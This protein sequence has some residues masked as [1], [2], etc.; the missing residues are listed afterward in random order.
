[1]Q[2]WVDQATYHGRSQHVCLTALEAPDRLVPAALAAWCVAHLNGLP[3]TALPSSLQVLGYDIEGAQVIDDDYRPY[4]KEPYW[5]PVMAFEDPG[6][7]LE[8]MW[9]DVVSYDVLLD[10]LAEPA[11]GTAHR[12]SRAEPN[13]GIT[14]P[15]SSALTIGGEVVR[16]SALA[17]A[18]PAYATAAET[19][20]LDVAELPARGA[21]GAPDG[22]GEYRLRLLGA[23]GAVLAE[24]AFT[25]KFDA[26]YPGLDFAS[27]IFN[28]PAPQ[29]L[30][31]VALVRGGVVIATLAASAA[32]PQVTIQAPNGSSHSGDLTVRWTG[33]DADAGATV[34]Y[35]V[36][37]GSEDGVGWRMVS[38]A[39]TGT[40]LTLDTTQHAN[41]AACRL[42]VIA[43]DGFLAG[44][45][46][47]APFSISNPPRATTTWPGDGAAGVP[48]WPAITAS[49]RD[50]MDA[51]SIN[52][53][54]FTLVDA[55]GQAVAGTVSYHDDTSTAVFRPTGLLQRGQQYIA[56][57]TGTIRAAG[58]T[59][60]GS[61][62]FWRFTVR[63]GPETSMYLPLIRR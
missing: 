39:T 41:C 22:T 56:R 20:R 9:M 35:T 12:P 52:E 58:G 25:P 21:F 26:L 51:T 34:T 60:L 55:K 24:H 11:A 43:S 15:L 45:A 14:L 5:R 59:P 46:Q 10:V 48:V 29:G 63:S 2:G 40:Q 49:F 33:S 47:S 62:A 36:M 53:S 6:S 7:V 28:V 42:K 54:S 3:D 27:F 38:P 30:R 32:A 37:L 8:A 61:D 16:R 50:A 44:S 17:A 57:L 19:A 4:K 1:V 13:A 18:G 31:S 23:S